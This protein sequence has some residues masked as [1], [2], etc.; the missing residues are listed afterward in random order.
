M[1][2]TWLFFLLLSGRGIGI[3]PASPTGESIVEQT[4]ADFRVGHYAA[5]VE[6]LPLPAASLESI[7]PG[8]RALVF[9]LVGAALELSGKA[10]DARSFY[11][12][13]QE[14]RDNGEIAGIP[15][16][17]GICA[18]TLAVFREVCGPPS[19]DHPHFLYKQPLPVREIV[20]RRPQKW[21]PP[22]REKRYGSGG[23]LLSP[24]GRV[25]RERWN[26]HVPVARVEPVVDGGSPAVIGWVRFVPSRRWS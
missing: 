20:R 7:S 16:L 9:L 23:S 24:P 1:T 26:R 5:I 15:R 14:M 21:N 13:V 10:E 3:A 22:E 25:N 18:E 4:M 11:H 17:D 6:R 19:P 8:Q 2:W 12:H